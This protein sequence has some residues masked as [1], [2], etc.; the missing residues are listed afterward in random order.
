MMYLNMKN[1]QIGIIIFRS[2]F[3]LKGAF[4]KNLQNKDKTVTNR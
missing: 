2:I 4:S 3:E 1:N